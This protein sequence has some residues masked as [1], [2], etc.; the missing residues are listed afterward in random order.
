MNDESGKLFVVNHKTMIEKQ[1]Q[2][3]GIYIY[4]NYCI[5]T[6]FIIWLSTFNEINKILTRPS[7]Y[8]EWNVLNPDVSMIK[9][10]IAYHDKWVLDDEYRSTLKLIED[11]ISFFFFSNQI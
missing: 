2:I 9:A 11:A 8:E 3:F 10:C 6:N 4:R 5:Q 7:F 1:I